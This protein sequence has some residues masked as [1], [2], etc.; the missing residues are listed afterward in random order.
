MGSLLVWKLTNRVNREFF[1]PC[2]R[3]IYEF[4]KKFSEG[5]DKKITKKDLEKIG[6]RNSFFLKVLYC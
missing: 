1:M 2:I 3:I 5:M 4:S 6:R